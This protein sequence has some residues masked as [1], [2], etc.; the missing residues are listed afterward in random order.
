MYP[1]SRSNGIFFMVADG[2]E[3]LVYCMSGSH[4]CQLLCCVPQKIR[5]Y[6]SRV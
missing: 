5:R 6:C 4:S 1:M 3:F 2:Q